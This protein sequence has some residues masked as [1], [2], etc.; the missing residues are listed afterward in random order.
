MLYNKGSD[1]KLHHGV[2]CVYLCRYV[3]STCIKLSPHCFICA[4]RPGRITSEHYIVI[5]LPNPIGG[6]EIFSTNLVFS[7]K[8]GMNQVQKP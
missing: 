1:A 6:F 5:V 2:Q 4:E 3:S 7:R 8:G